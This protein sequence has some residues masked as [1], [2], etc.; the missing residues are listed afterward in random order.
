MPQYQREKSTVFVF[1]AAELLVPGSPAVLR[2]TSALSASPLGTCRHSRA[3][4]AQMQLAADKVQTLKAVNGGLTAIT[5]PL[6]P[7]DI[8]SYWFTF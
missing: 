8:E 5:I 7:F 3:R 6:P 4:E 1:T 2:P